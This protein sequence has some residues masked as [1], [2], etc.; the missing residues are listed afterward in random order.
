LPT[1]SVGEAKPSTFCAF[2]TLAPS[3]FHTL[4]CQARRDRGDALF[5]GVRGIGILGSSNAES[6]IKPRNTLGIISPGA[7]HCP[8]PLGPVT[9]MDRYARLWMLSD[10]KQMF[11]DLCTHPQLCCACGLRRLGR[12]YPPK[13]R[14]HRGRVPTT[15]STSRSHFSLRPPKPSRLLSL[16]HSFR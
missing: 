3:G 6:W 5:S 1:T 15:R 11:V 12:G 9:P 7:P 8:A 4:V 10:W 16:I 14:R 2:T 13:I